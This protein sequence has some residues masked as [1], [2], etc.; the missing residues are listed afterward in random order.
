VTRDGLRIS[1]IDVWPVD[2]GLRDAFVI[3]GGAMQAAELGFVKVALAGG[4]VG[5][6]EIAPFAAVTGEGRDDSLRVA[7]QL[8]DG[9]TGASVAHYRR[10]SRDMAE[11]AP[12][13]RAAR[14]GLE[15]ALLDAFCRAG[16]FP[17]WALWGGLVDAPP[18]TDITIPILGRERSLELARHWRRQGFNTLKLKVGVDVDGE[19]ALVAAIAREWPE[20]RFI[21]DANEGF[22]VAQALRFAEALVK[23]GCQTELFEQPVAKGDLAGMA[24]VR[25]HC[26]FPILADESVNSLSDARR[27]I[28]AGAADAINLKI[29]KAGILETLDIAS[30]A[31]AH[32]LKL[33]I[34]GM[35]E[36]RLTMGCS[37]A[38]ALGCGGVDWFDLDTPLLMETDPWRGG[39]RYDGPNLIP[40][41]EPGL[42]TT[43][44]P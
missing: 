5:Y 39:F 18:E 19:L 34:G 35:V 3:A 23:L 21:F 10:L 33:M 36:T 38:I 12:E 16:G 43:P 25:A 15:M 4:A 11:K 14:C 28:E 17:L 9:L 8:A 42:G 40:W 27:V 7:R 26:P 44:T 1:A 29:T 2:V 32:G 20:A 6:G 22:S 24:R 13:A 30:L 37:L 41:L 31:R